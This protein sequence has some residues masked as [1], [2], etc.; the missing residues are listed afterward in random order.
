MKR[1]DFIAFL[2]GA[3]AA[4]PPAARAQQAESVR[5]LGYLTSARQEDVERRVAIFKRALQ[6]LGWTEG[7]NIR[8]D[9]R[10]GAGDVVRAGKLAKELVELRPD[11]I[12]A[13]STN[14][15]TAVRQH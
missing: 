1:R 9:Y 13:A 7:R 6:E 2:G 8:I 15:A 11:V 10:F 12:F 14:A 3:V 4:W 5:R